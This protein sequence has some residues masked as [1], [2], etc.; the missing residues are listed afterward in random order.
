MHTS[1]VVSKYLFKYRTHGSTAACLWSRVTRTIDA[2]E[3]VGNA[4]LWKVNFE[5]HICIRF[6]FYWLQTW[7]ELNRHII[8]EHL[9]FQRALL[10][11]NFQSPQKVQHDGRQE[12]V[13]LFGFKLNGWHL[14][15]DKIQRDWPFNLHAWHT[16][17][18]KAWIIRWTQEYA[19]LNTALLLRVNT[20]LTSENLTLM[21]WNCKGLKPAM[22]CADQRVGVWPPV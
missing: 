15:E 6:L 2:K 13:F 5:F 12:H 18:Q 20:C 8:I 16:C 9:K 3:L 21:W 7:S 17:L 22:N 10:L 4:R 1:L 19:P 14:I 11:T